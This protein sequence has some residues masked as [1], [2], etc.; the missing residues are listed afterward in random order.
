MSNNEILRASFDRLAQRLRALQFDRNLDIKYD[1]IAF[2]SIN[3]IVKDG[4][5][6]ENPVSLTRHFRF[7]LTRKPSDYQSIL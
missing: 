7:S 5:I 6:L 4:G 3:D 2:H 1:Y